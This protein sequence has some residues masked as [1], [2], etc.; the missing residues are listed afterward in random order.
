MI[1]PLNPILA[2]ILREGFK[3]LEKRM[4]EDEPD[5]GV[6]L[7]QIEGCLTPIGPTAKVQLY[8]YKPHAIDPLRFSTNGFEFR[9]GEFYGT[10][11][12]SIPEWAEKLIPAK[13]VRLQRD[14]F[15]DGYLPHDFACRQ[16]WIYVR[17]GATGEWRQMEMNAKQADVLLHKILSAPTMARPNHPSI[18]ASRLEA[19]AIYQAVRKY[20]VKSGE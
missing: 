12:G 9:A 16:K 6:N 2:A 1:F 17:K 20:H 15:L 14:A 11:L 18:S 3:R 5:C 7:G 4:M 19:L 8:H 10:D 13:Y